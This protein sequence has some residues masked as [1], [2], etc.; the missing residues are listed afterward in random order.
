[1]QLLEEGSLMLHK[2]T[3]EQQEEKSICNIYL[4]SAQMVEG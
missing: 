1:M 3:D 2:I 4:P